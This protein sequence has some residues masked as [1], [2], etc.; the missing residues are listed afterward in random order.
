ME[1][2]RRINTRAGHMSP[3]I[4]DGYLI[5]AYPTWAKV[6]NNPETLAESLGS[7]KDE[8]ITPLES[9]LMGLFHTVLNTCAPL[10]TCRMSCD[11]PC[12]RAGKHFDP[13]VNLTSIQSLRFE[14]VCHSFHFA[15]TVLEVHSHNFLCEQNAFDKLQLCCDEFA[16][17]VTASGGT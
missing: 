3:T 6:G 13:L 16:Q 8:I 4:V 11:V 5:K 2:R 12:C 1:A 17:R 10:L 9:G 7:R 15:A 14:Q